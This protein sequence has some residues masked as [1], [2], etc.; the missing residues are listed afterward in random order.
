MS[1]A[2]ALLVLGLPA[3]TPSG[4]TSVPF[5]MTDRAIIVDAVINDRNVSLLFDSGFGGTVL[6]DRNIDVGPSTGQMNLRDFVGEF[7]AETVTLKTLKLGTVVLHPDEKMIVK[8]PANFTEQYGRHVDGIL[9]LS[10]IKGMVCEIDFQHSR[11]VFFPQTVDIDKWVPD[12]KKTFLVKMLP[13]GGNAIELPVIA[14]SGLAMTMAL[15]TGN[16]FYATTHKDVLE[17][18]GIWKDGQAPTFMR[19]S[20]VAS[21]AV[22]TWTKKMPPMT[23]FGVPV[24]PTVWDVIDLP[25]SDARGDGTVGFGFLSNFNVTFDFTRRRVWLENWRSPIENPEIGDVGVSAHYS[26][27]DKRTVVH[28]VAPGSPADQAGIKE[29]DEVLAIGG[30]DLERPTFLQLRAMFEG[31]VG[32]TIEIAV[33]RNG[34]LKRFKVVRKALDN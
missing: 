18:V 10:A 29:G 8:M 23:I 28:L 33:S 26:A 34:A 24:Q 1:L 17:R 3:Q 5:K 31:P 6:I 14:P 32:S 21:G 19:E 12:N 22:D 13:I 9:G 25:S 4:G 11:F 27:E 20:G 15:D 2:L 30:T 7:G 16:S